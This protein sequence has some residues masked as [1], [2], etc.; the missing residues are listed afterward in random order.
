MGERKFVV[1][2]CLFGR[3]VG[4]GV[5]IFV[6]CDEC[7]IFWLYLMWINYDPSFSFSFQKKF[8]CLQIGP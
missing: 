1:R 5:S 3:E 4:L 2:A 6:R 7:E 8:A